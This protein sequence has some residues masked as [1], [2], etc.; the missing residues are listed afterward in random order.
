VVSDPQGC[1]WAK[2]PRGNAQKMTDGW[3]TG[4]R[5][6]VTLVGR[7][8]TRLAAAHRKGCLAEAEHARGPTPSSLGSAPV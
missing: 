2:R 7:Q 3:S 1:G 4:T 8:G 6:P 5:G